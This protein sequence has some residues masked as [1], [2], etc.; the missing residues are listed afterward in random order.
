MNR[1]LAGL[2]CLLLAAAAAPLG[3]QQRPY[4]DGPVI[5][6]TAVKVM[7]GQ[8][9]NYMEYL[10]GTW[11]KSMEASKEAGLVAEYRVY[12]AQAHDP[13][14]A[15][16]YLVTTY[17]NMAAFDGLDAKMDPIM[18]KVT[19]MNYRQADEASGKRV[20]MRTI[21]GSQIMREL[22]FK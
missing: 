18:A 14:E 13:E 19:R 21:L 11:R 15:D 5:V 7:D 16:L 22:V 3:A 12:S 4:E 17:P 8:F 1:L 6:V 9:E 2:F 20:V 10:N